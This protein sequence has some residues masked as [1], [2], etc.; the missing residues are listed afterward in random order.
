MIDSQS[1]EIK[2]GDYFAYAVRDGN[3]SAMNFGLVL[4]VEDERIKAITATMRWREGWHVSQRS[5]WL[6][7]GSKLIVVE[8]LSLELRALLEKAERD[9]KQSP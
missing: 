7:N 3:S 6:D 9:R 8:A 5:Q 1:N 2:P 4:E